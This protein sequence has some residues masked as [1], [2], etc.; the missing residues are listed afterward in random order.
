MIPVGIIP[1]V[2]L[3]A[4]STFLISHRIRDEQ[5]SR[6]HAL[7]RQISRQIEQ[8]IA[9]TVVDLELL[10]TDPKLVGPQLSDEE[11][12][13]E[14]TRITRPGFP[15]I[16]LLDRS[17]FVVETT[18]AVSEVQDYSPWFSTALSKQQ[19]VVSSPYRKAE[20]EQLLISFY[21][22]VKSVT[23]TKTAIIKAS[24]SFD[25]I[26][27]ILDSV[28]PARSDFLALVDGRG[29]LLDATTSD[30]PLEALKE[31][32]LRNRQAATARGT[33]HFENSSFLV[34]SAHEVS[35]PNQLEFTRTW[36]LT[37]FRDPE[38]AM[39]IVYQSRTCKAI[40]AAVGVLLS[41]LLGWFLSK[42]VS[43]R[44]AHDQAPSLQSDD[45]KL[46]VFTPERPRKKSGGA[47]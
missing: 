33:H 2:V 4:V 41:L 22:P 38:G 25:R 21:I 34:Y 30:V 16:S 24:L 9:S 35:P 37:Y 42:R 46:E 14:L 28:E 39:A 27:E 17:G 10:A 3:A 15:E 5:L 8:V 40:A 26:S 18:G 11:R 20:H 32:G 29:N 19:T 12:K 13:R 31:I 44:I 36:M 47:S 43:H 1:V 7:A 6:D 23:A 45:F